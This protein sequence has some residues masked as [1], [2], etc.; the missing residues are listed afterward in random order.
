MQ[1]HDFYITQVHTHASHDGEV[2]IGMT[3]CTGDEILMTIPGEL[4]Y[5]ELSYII[6]NAL[7]AK[8]E[9]ELQINDRTRTAVKHLAAFLPPGKRGRKPKK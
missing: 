5:S 2:M 1:E 8:H 6:N 4:L 9:S 7:A 3:D